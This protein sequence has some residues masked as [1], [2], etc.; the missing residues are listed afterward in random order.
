MSSPQSPAGGARALLL[1]GWIVGCGQDPYQDLKN[2]TVGLGAVDPVTFPAEN[3]GDQGNRMQPGSGV[4][5]ETPAFVGGQPVGYFAYPVKTAPGRDPLRVLDN[6][7][8]YPPVAT[9]TA[10]AFDAADQ[11]PIPAQNKCS[12]PPG[13][14]PD[15]RLDPIT[16]WYKMQGNIFTDLPKATYTPGVASA[17]TYVPVVAEAR[18]SSGGHTC[19]ELK[20]EKGL[21]TARGGK[22]PKPTGNYLAWLIIDPAASVFAFD[23]PDQTPATSI[24]LQKW[25]WYNRYLVAYLDG[26]YIPAPTVEINV[27]TV[28]MPQMQPVTRMVPQRL[29]YP[30]QISVIDPMTMM[31]MAVPGKRGDGYDVLAARRGA[32]GYSPIC[33]VVTY[34]TPMPL[35][36]EML[37]KDAAAIDPAFMAT[38]MPGTPRYVYCLQ[39]R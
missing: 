28:D 16:G 11:A 32:E 2:E 38:F 39:V 10:Y 14:K 23:D 7:K 35:P 22:L 24:V 1:V 17:S 4:F 33:E 3:L 37:P 27:G 19:Q 36:V 12:P 9:P 13:Y 31:P 18:V 26:G 20:S 21:S 25:G 34:A 29:Y 6:G 15:R 8:P 30:R 5:T